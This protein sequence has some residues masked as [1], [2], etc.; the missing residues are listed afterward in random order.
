MET[1][2]SLPAIFLSSIN[3]RRARVNVTKVPGTFQFDR[4]RDHFYRRTTSVALDNDKLHIRCPNLLFIGYLAS[5]G[6]I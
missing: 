4:Y 6:D 1:E 5:R 3:G 2:R